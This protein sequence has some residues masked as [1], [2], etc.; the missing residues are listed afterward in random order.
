MN[1]VY[2]TC[3]VRPTVETSCFSGEQRFFQIIKSIES[4]HKKV[5][6]CF[7]VLLETGSATSE[8]KEVLSKLVHLYMTVNVTTLIKS[9]GE[10][11]MIHKFLSSSWFQENK[12][13]FSTFSKLSGRYFLTDSFDFSKYPLD[14]IFIRFRWGGESEGLF[15]TRYY[16]IPVSKI[17][18]YTQNLENLLRNHA[19]VF[20]FLDV[21]H[22]YFLLNFFPLEDTIND[23][24]IG[25]AGWMTGDG[26]YI[27]E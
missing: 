15:E 18:L 6:N 24:S 1:L 16:R 12:G 11:T 13:R 23:Q 26:R 8:E 4:V 19:Y 3:A 27:E 10:A 22:L 5:P 25:L 7:I 21:E 20:K 9:M 2:I 14:K 17:D